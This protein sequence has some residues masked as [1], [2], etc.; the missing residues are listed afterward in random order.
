MLLLLPESHCRQHVSEWAWLRSNKPLF[1]NTGGGPDLVILHREALG[2][3]K[4]PVSLNLPGA[5]P[6]DPAGN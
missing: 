4:C 2:C 1:T 5:Q 3:N 6:W